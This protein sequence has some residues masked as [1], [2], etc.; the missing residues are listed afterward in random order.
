MGLENES[1]GERRPGGRPDQASK[2]AVAPPDPSVPPS[3]GTKPALPVS[4]ESTAALSV[5]GK[6]APPQPPAGGGSLGAVCGTTHRTADA[7]PCSLRT[8]ALPCR[9]SEKLR[10]PLPRTGQAAGST[11]IKIDGPA[12]P[13]RPGVAAS[14]LPSS[15][16]GAQTRPALGGVPRGL[17][18]SRFLGT[19][20]APGNRMDTDRLTTAI[21]AGHS[22]WA[23]VI[24]GGGLP[25]PERQN[26]AVR[27][28]QRLALWKY[29]GAILGTSTQG[30]SRVPWC[31]PNQDSVGMLLCT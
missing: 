5:P 20:W 26:Q 11:W 7:G 2:W 14:R 18:P 10:Q 24:Q 21:W 19:S 1:G 13:G 6:Q 29:R 4:L 3:E 27:A 12:S 16:D 17:P 22:G 8:R 31:L 23:T 25:G 30:R 9:L 15:R 28:P